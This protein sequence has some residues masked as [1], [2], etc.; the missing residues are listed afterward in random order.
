MINFGLSPE[1]VEEVRNYFNLIKEPKQEIQV[2]IFGSRATGNAKPYSDVDLLISA[3]PLMSAQQIS[4]LTLKLEES[5]L[6][7]KFDLVTQ[8]K[9][10]LPYLKT[11]HDEKFL[12]FNLTPSHR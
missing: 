5:N 1:Q 10:Y 12:L 3:H 9:V 11:I 4:E 6:P 2:W 7:F 8:E